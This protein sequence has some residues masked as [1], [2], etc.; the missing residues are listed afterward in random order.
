MALGQA[1]ETIGQRF[2]G[3]R[4]GRFEGCAAG[5]ESGTDVVVDRTCGTRVRH[6]MSLLG[7]F[8]R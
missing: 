4:D 8:L 5:P 2:E 1:A 7:S 3:R 6:W